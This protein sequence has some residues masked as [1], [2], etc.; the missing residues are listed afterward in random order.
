MSYA[1]NLPAFRMAVA[2]SRAVQPKLKLFAQKTADE[3]QRAR[4][5]ERGPQR[6]FSAREE[7]RSRT[8]G[9]FGKLTLPTREHPRLRDGISL[10]MACPNGVWARGKKDSPRPWND[11]RETEFPAIG[12]RPIQC[13]LTSY[14]PVSVASKVSSALRRRNGMKLPDGYLPLATKRS[15]NHTT[16]IPKASLWERDVQGRN[17]L[18]KGDAYS[19]RIPAHDCYCPNSGATYR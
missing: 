3:T 6:D 4:R 1:D 16:C 13:S 8:E 5:F 2:G 12:V 19:G 17:S 11:Q 10:P 18:L 14:A 15:F 7:D 9:A